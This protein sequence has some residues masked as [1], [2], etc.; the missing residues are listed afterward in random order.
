MSIAIRYSKHLQEAEEIANDGFI[1]MFKNLDKYSF[2]KPFDMWLRRIV[3]NCAI[4][5][6]RKEYK[7]SNIIKLNA[8]QNHDYNTAELKMDAAYLTNCINKLS[9]KYRLTFNLSVIDGFSH[10]EISEKL[11]IS[12]GTVKSNL[13]KARKSL[14]QMI[15]NQNSIASSNKGN[16]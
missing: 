10:Q 8:K 5:H 6:Y 12:V 11:N 7:K 15:K 16:L 3:I 4:D 13:H 14:Q 2:D 1:K 9:P